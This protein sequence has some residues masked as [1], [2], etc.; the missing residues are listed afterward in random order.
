MENATNNPPAAGLVSLQ[1][2]KKPVSNRVRAGFGGALGG[3]GLA[4]GA[5]AV[6]DWFVPSN[7]MPE[8]VAMFV[9]T[10]LSA[11]VGA[12]GGWAQRDD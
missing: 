2:E 4:F 6:W 10:L 8:N 12:I 9:T 3:G 11:V 5:K 7:P 1:P